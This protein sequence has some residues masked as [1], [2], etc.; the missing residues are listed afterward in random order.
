MVYSIRQPERQFPSCFLLFSSFRKRKRG[1]KAVLYIHVFP[2]HT[3]AGTL[4][5]DKLKRQVYFGTRVGK[6]GSW[7][8]P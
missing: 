4:V 6:Q 2:L 1:G 7:A 8:R 5:A 3:M